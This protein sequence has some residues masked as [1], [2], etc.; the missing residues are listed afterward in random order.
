MF[1]LSVHNCTLTIETFFMLFLQ[2]FIDANL[3]TIVRGMNYKTGSYVIIENTAEQVAIYIYTY[4]I[5][6]S[7]TQYLL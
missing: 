4:S 1:Q 5:I 6:F 7:D 3:E 2:Y